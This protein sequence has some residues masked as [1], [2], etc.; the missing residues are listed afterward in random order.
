MVP[1][2]VSESLLCYFVASLARQGLAPATIKTYL[3]GVR[4]AQIMRGFEEPRQH[5]TLPR[6]HLLQ[7]G[8]K[9]VRFQQGTPQSRQRLPILPSHLRQ[10]RMVW[11]ISPAPDALMLWAAVTLT[12]FGF[13][14]SGEVTVPSVTAFNPTVHLCWGNVSVDSQVA[15]T[16]LK[17]HL[18]VSKCDQFGRGIN[19][20]IGHTEDDLCPVVAVLNYIAQRGDQPG[21]FFRFSDHTPLTKARFVTKVREALTSAGVDCSGYSGHSFRIGAATTAAR[22]GVADSVIQT[23]GRWT[24]AAFLGYIRTPQEELARITRVLARTDNLTRR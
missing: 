2:P 15:P 16:T 6:L 14:R 11:G 3:A 9:R 24:S 4:H 10:I 17:V 19:V 5:S 18:K 1:F 12:F 23:L 20:F 22:A 13:F 21:P 8:V 7:A